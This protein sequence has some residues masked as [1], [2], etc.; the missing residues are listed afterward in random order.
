MTMYPRIMYHLALYA[1][2][3]LALPCI[4]NAAEVPKEVSTKILSDEAV[5]EDGWKQIKLKGKDFEMTVWGSANKSIYGDIDNKYQHIEI[6]M[7]GGESVTDYIDIAGNKLKLEDIIFAPGDSFEL[8]KLIPGA[9]REQLVVEGSEWIPRGVGSLGIYEI[10]CIDKKGITIL[11]SLITDRYRS[12]DESTDQPSLNLKAT[13]QEKVENGKL[14]IVYRYQEDGGEYHT[15]NFL[16]N[17]R[18][19]V[20]TTGK[21]KKID[22]EYSP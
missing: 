7:N 13:V 12:E 19:F 18:A 22:K 14:V 11:L 16:W 9:P 20:D 1:F 2:V 8:K 5:A 10:F 17:G 15:I 6:I 21:Y 4:S 3:L